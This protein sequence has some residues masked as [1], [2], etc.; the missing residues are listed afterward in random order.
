MIILALARRL[1]DPKL[2]GMRLSLERLPETLAAW[3]AVLRRSLVIA[4]K[5]AAVASRAMHWMLSLPSAT[6]V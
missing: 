4:D 6:V 5:L 1:H 2:L 3:S